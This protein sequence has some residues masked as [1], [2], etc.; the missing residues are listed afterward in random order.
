[1]YTYEKKKKKITDFGAVV[2][3]SLRWTQ[4]RG[5]GEKDAIPTRK[6]ESALVGHFFMIVTSS[7]LFDKKNEARKH[8]N[9]IQVNILI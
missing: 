1:M 2:Q 4:R 8:Y 5:C 7:F 6:W 3:S 9:V